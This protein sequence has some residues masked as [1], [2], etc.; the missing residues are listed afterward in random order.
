MQSVIAAVKNNS[1]IENYTNKDWIMII[2]GTNDV[3]DSSK[4]NNDGRQLPRIMAEMLKTQVAA[5]QH[6]YL[7]I[8]TVPTGM[9]LKIQL[10]KMK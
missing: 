10:S 6:T 8:A 5:M 9:M 1:D 4:S 3:A 2:G 7:I